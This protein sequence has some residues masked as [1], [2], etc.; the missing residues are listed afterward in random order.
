MMKCCTM[1]DFHN[2]GLIFAGHSGYPSGTLRSK[3]FQTTLI[4]AFEVIVQSHGHI[5]WHFQ[6][7]PKSWKSH[8]VPWHAIYNPHPWYYTNMCIKRQI[9]NDGI[10]MQELMDF[11]S[12]FLTSLRTYVGLPH[13]LDYPKISSQCIKS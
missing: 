9:A 1:C 2:F 3:K 8:I 6:V 12:S 11:W 5:L 13:F 10:G 4:L 7:R